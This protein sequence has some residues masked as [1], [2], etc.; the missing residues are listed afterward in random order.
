MSDGNVAQWLAEVRSLQHQ[1]KMLQ[2]EREEAYS[3]ADNWRKLYESE[4]QQRRKDDAA[5]RRKIEKLQQGLTESHR[6][7]AINQGASHQLLADVAAIRGTQSVQ[8]LQAQ[9]IATKRQCEQLKEKLEAEQTE[10][11][12]TRE[13]LTAALG[14]AVDLLAKE[15]T[16]T[17]NK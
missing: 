15:R 11:E 14:D 8:A 7:E 9:L 5:S 1:V 4:A 3:S 6:T 13:S 17:S 16:E 2:K 10:H 12:Q